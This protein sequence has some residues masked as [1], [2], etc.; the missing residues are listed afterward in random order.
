M[1]KFFDSINRL[2]GVSSPGEL[3]FH[4][5]FIGFCVIAFIYF[6]L[7]RMKFFAI[8]VGGL[9][10]GAAVVH[11]LYPSSTSNLPELIKFLAAMG[12]LAL[13]LVYIGFVRD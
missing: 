6:V 9:V 3:V 5:V 11:Y 10:G 2:L 7:T 13:L 12:G 1:A 4:P 8:A